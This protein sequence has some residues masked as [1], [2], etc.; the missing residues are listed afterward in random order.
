MWLN[1]VEEIIIIAQLALLLFVIYGH[2]ILFMKI[3]V[4]LPLV[5]VVL[6]ALIHFGSRFCRHE[7]SSYTLLESIDL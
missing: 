1:I 3:A 2:S 7:E 6:F 5:G 4:F